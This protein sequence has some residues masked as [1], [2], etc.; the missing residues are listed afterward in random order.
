ML[1]VKAFKKPLTSKPLTIV[2]ASK[3]KRVFIIKIKSPKVK[4]LIGRVKT[5]KIGFKL[6]L[7][8]PKNKATQRAVQIPL[9]I[10]P[11]TK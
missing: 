9:T 4:I 8:S 7:N 6:T 10:T 5:I 3:I 1:K 11:G 2:E